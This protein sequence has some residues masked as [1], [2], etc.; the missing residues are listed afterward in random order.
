M[1]T[2]RINQVAVIKQHPCSLSSGAGSLAVVK[3]HPE[4]RPFKQEHRASAFLQAKVPFINNALG[5]SFLN[6]TGA[7]SR[8]LAINPTNPSYYKNFILKKRFNIVATARNHRSDWATGAIP[9]SA[10]FPLPESNG[11]DAVSR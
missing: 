2:G 11:N 1:T 8:D 9:P 7:S 3:S 5:V 10:K 4:E 6:F